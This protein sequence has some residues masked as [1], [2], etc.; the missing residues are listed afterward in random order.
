[1][2]IINPFEKSIYNEK[3]DDLNTDTEVKTPPYGLNTK[4]EAACHFIALS[5]WFDVS[6]S[7]VPHLPGFEPSLLPIVSICDILDTLDISIEEK[8]K[9]EGK[10]ELTSLEMA[11]ANGIL[12]YPS[13]VR[14]PKHANGKR[15]PLH[16]HPETFR[17][18][19]WIV[20]SGSNDPRIHIFKDGCEV[21]AA[22]KSTYGSGRRWVSWAYTTWDNDIDG[23]QLLAWQQERR[24]NRKAA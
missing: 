21:T 19:L 7:D 17:A 3:G 24:D 22:G 6:Y 11:F 12:D 1:M 16:A 5:E 13:L 20:G 9:S 2:K 8:F 10:E 23:E 4:E 14:I 18:G 15:K